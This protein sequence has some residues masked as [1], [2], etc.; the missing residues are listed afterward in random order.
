M[1]SK[2]SF[3]ILLSIIITICGA[4]N[5]LEYNSY[6][7]TT[8]DIIFFS[9]QDGTQIKIY[10]TEGQLAWP[11]GPDIILSKGQHAWADFENVNQVYKVCGSNKFAVLTGDPTTQGISGYYAM[12]AN[13]LGTSTEFYTYVPEESDIVSGHQ[14]FVVFGYEPNTSVTVQA[15]D[16]NGVYQD[17]DTFTLDK[18]QHW[19]DPNLDNKYIHIIADKPVSAL[20]C[21]DQGYFVPS[22]NGRWSGTEFYTYV[23][24]I[25]GYQ[26]DPWVEDLIVTA[27]DND[28]SVTITDS[29]DPNIVIWSGTLNSGDSWVVSCPEDA[30]LDT[31][32]TIESSKTVTVSVMPW[33][34]WPTT[35]Y[36]HGVFVPDRGGTGIGRYG[37]DI[38][39]STINDGYL[40][41]LAYT[42]NTHV[43]LYNSENGS[44]VA[45]YALNEGKS[46]NANPGYGLWR[47]VSDRY[48]SAY[49]GFGTHT[50]EFAPLAFDT[51]PPVLAL[52]K[53]D[54]LD[55]NDPNDWVVP[56]DYITYTITYGNPITDPNNPNYVGTVNDVN[57]VDYLPVGVTYESVDPNN[58]FD[59]NYNS[60]DHTYTWHI[61]TLSPGDVNSVTLKVE[62]NKLAEPLGTITNFC[63]IESDLYYT[64]AS[65][66]TNVGCCGGDII[67]VDKWA[68]GSN[69]GTSWYNAYTDLQNALA[70]A[71]AGCGSEIWVASGTYK[72]TT[73]VED[74]NTAFELVNGVDIYGGFAGYESAITQRNLMINQTILDGNLPD[75]GV[76][77]VVS[78][79]DVNEATI[80][81]GFTIT[82]G[83]CG[84]ICSVNSSLIIRHNRIIDNGYGIICINWSSV[85]VTNCDIIKNRGG[86]SVQGGGIYCED[87]NSL[88]VTN[89]IISKNASDANGGGIC[90][91]DSNNLTVTNCTITDNEAG[92][93][94]GAIYNY[95]SLFSAITDSTFSGNSA[96]EGGGLLLYDSSSPNIANCIFTGNTATY[97][98]GAMSS[99]YSSPTVVNCIFSGNKADYGGGICNAYQPSPAI[100]NC[101]F[102]GNSVGTYGGG[103]YNYGALLE[104]DIANCIFW[105]NDAVTG[106]NE[107]YNDGTSESN[108]TYSD[109]NGGWP[110]NE[111]INEDPCFFDVSDLNGLWAENASYDSSTFQSTL[112]DYSA[113]WVVNGLAGKFVNPD[114]P[115]QYLQFFIVSNDANTIKVWSDVESIAGDGDTYHIFDYHLSSDSNCI[116]RGDPDF[117]PDANMTDIDGERRVVDGD[118]NGTEIVDMGAD[119]YYRSPADFNSDGIVN[120][121][122][123][124]LFANFWQTTSDVYDLIDDNNYIDYNDLA[125]F[126]EDWL[127]Q[128]AWAKAFPFSYGQGMGKSMG[129]GMSEGLGLAEEILPSASA[130]KPQP[131]VT[132]ADIVELIKWLEELWL[133]DAEVRKMISEDEWL[134]FIESVI[135]SIKEQR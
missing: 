33:E 134:K 72:P 132:K 112:T 20:T 26:E 101:T 22:A 32:Y 30:N 98:G 35:G 120:F 42:D 110:G 125:R 83:W 128:R 31:Y 68:N 12:D 4:A 36:H 119:E 122:D 116:D 88:I 3:I 23:S 92:N 11:E 25:G 91:K 5:A 29:N 93:Y 133:T 69:S 127:W 46:V 99:Y 115:N 15:E 6:I 90:C 55:H 71:D 27:Y 124:A 100:I 10:D 95:N 77:N 52:E 107:I 74:Y 87:S 108:V 82:N 44:W 70:R 63:E 117:N 103:M 49:S 80:I 51:K 67:Y 111:N 41:I 131:Q 58:P 81:D 60:N 73:E 59:P 96:D 2:K 21:Y 50:A 61:E 19:A 75:Y 84:G 57:I 114:T 76:V 1:F 56:G 109:I 39:G 48:V 123:Y 7:F 13:G 34:L 94:G 79:N 53:D 47:I 16:P 102:S 64:T 65:E 97:Y 129:L 17:V 37:S 130:K 45:G 78:A 8:E 85:N 43:D 105:D 113:N 40:T 135:Q 62:V 54:N 38:I 66:D 118:A 28:T 9:Y 104:P 14:L 106:G 126:C 18:G 86:T 89:C 121:F 24:D